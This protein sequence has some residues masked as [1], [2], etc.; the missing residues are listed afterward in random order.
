MTEEARREEKKN[1]LLEWT[2]T[3]QE[4]DCQ[5]AVAARMADL[6]SHVA[7]KLRSE[8]EKLIFSGDSTPLQYMQRELIVEAAGL[9]VLAICGVRDAIRKLLDRQRD[10]RPRMAAFNLPQ[11]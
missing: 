7:S 3:A 10:L 8:P 1:L 4:L 6:L 2:E 5:K 11:S 9:D